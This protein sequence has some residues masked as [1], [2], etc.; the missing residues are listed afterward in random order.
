[1]KKGRQEGIVRNC[2]RVPVGDMKKYSFPYRSIAVWNRLKEETV[3]VRT[4]HEF[5]AKL[6]L[7]HHG[8][9]TARA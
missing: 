1:M 6:D 9:G 5:K 2:K 8:D 7:E 3:C 4:I